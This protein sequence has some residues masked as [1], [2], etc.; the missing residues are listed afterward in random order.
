VYKK[1]K[2]PTDISEWAIEKLVSD[3]EKRIKGKN[4]S[5]EKGTKFARPNHVE[6]KTDVVTLT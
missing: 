2:D 5:K 4:A 1:I 3:M 6:E